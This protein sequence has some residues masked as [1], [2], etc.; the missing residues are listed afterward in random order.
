MEK[1][2]ISI[3]AWE[4]TE[5]LD[6]MNKALSFADNPECI[7]FGLGLNYENEP[8]FSSIKNKIKIIRDKTDYV[9]SNPGIIQVR[10]GIRRLITDEKYFLSIDAHA[11]FDK[12]WDT[13]L[14]SDIENLNKDGVKYVISKQ[15]VEPGNYKNYYTKWYLNKDRFDIGGQPEHDFNHTYVKNKMVN[16]NYFLNYYMSGNFIFGHTAWIKSMEFP[17]YHGFP[18]EEPELSMAL[19]CNGFDVVSPTGEHC[20]IHAGND[21]KYQFPYDEKWWEFVG[22]DRNNPR[23]WKKIWVWDDPDMEK[24]VISLLTTGQNKY[25]SFEGLQRTVKEFYSIIGL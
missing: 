25:F 16:D 22:T 3:P 14:V 5:I 17:D 2:F 19:F 24:E 11:N 7:V 18:F 9:V 23:H 21:P 10:N 4:D 6:T 20:P 15:I 12:G 13:T 1:I 8:D